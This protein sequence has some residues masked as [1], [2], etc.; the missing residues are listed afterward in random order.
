MLVM[1]IR[2]PR[3][4]PS[5]LTTEG[6]SACLEAYASARPRMMQLTTINGT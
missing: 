4:V 5:A 3:L 1:A 2:K 6:S